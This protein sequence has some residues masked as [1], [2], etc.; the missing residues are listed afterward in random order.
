MNPV[1]TQTLHLQDCWRIALIQCDIV[2]GKPKVNR[3]NLELAMEQAATAAEKPDIILLPELWNTG[4]ALTE[5]GALAD[6]EGRDSRKWLSSFARRHAIHVVGGSIAE[7]REGQVYNTMPVINRS[8]EEVAS[9]SKIHLFRLM[10][11]EKYLQPGERSVT[12]ELDGLQAGAAICYDIRFPE[13]ARRLALQGAKL[14]FV[15]AEWPHPRLNHWRMLLAARAIENQMYVVA[16]NRTGKSGSDAF[17]GH[18]LIIDPWGEIVAEGGEGEEIVT[19]SIDL[20]LVDQ[21]RRQIPVFADRRPRCY[22]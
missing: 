22:E 1:S 8:G 19:G 10:E 11:E 13:L 12:F 3:A 18:S 6:P 16:C 14:L 17:F 4:Y 7:I 21:V 15:A 20:S 5:I 2:L 9:Y